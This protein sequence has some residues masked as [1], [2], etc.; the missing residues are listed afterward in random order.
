M[1]SG[2]ATLRTIRLGEYRQEA[3]GPWSV[4]AMICWKD[5][6]AYLGNSDQVTKRL[7]Q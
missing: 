7:D 6:Q 2:R 5:I 1:P 3:D 4:S